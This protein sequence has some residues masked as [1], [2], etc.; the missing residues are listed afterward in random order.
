MAEIA[1]GPLPQQDTMLLTRGTTHHVLFR[2]E[3][4]GGYDRSNLMVKCPKDAVILCFRGMDCFSSW[5]WDGK[6]FVEGN[7]WDE[8]TP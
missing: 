8:T 1:T 7:L 5:T 2:G 3:L 6:T 4:A